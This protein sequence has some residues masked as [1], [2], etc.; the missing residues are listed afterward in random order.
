MFSNRYTDKQNMNSRKCGLNY[1]AASMLLAGVFVVLLAVLHVIKSDLDP[2]WHFISEYEIGNHGWMMQLAFVALA[3]SNLALLAAVGPYLRDVWGW[4]GLVMFLV[5]T[6][7]T[8][9]AGVF[10]SDAITATPALATPSG[11]WHNLGGTLGLAGVLGT[12]IISWKLVRCDAWRASRRIM[13]LAVA[14]FA[15]GFLV[16]F[17]SIAV[18]AVRHDGV[19]GPDVPVGWP[20]RLGILAGCAWL[21]LVG[22][23]AKRIQ[24]SSGAVS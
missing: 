13:L 3:A 1:P 8:L 23:Q 22:W 10:V 24:G 21:M 15:V 2:S 18:L 20:N 12:M 5:G 16:S 9:L 7:G 19:F 11:Q 14:I 6:A 17:V 4:I